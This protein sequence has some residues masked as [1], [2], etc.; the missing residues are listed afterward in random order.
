MASF[1]SASA[2]STAAVLL[3]SVSSAS[4]GGLVVAWAAPAR[5]ALAAPLRAAAAQGSANSAPVMMESKVKKR[6]KKGAG[7]GGLPAAID[8]EI[9]EAEQYLATDGQEPTPED[10]PFEMVD[11]DGMSV[12][13]LKRDYK[14]EK[15][16][17]IVSMPNVEGDPEFDEDDEGDD[18]DA[19]KDDDDEDEDGQESSLSM[20]VIVSK[21]SGLN[22]EF[23]CTAF[24][25]EITIDD[26]M[27]AEKTES[28]AEKFPFEGPEFTELPPNVQKGLFKFLEVR[29]VTLTT[30]NFMHDY[31]I[32]KQTKEYVRWMTKLKGLVQ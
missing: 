18:E 4:R 23:T 14:D 29:G 21:G 1:V 26:M 15:I 9:R 27:I 28:D 3:R 7:A 25:E 32:T 30:T 5:R 8:L 22:L 16:E 6:N 10:F 12:V 20:K 13:I 17:V 31:M 24:H 2:S 11:E 19:A